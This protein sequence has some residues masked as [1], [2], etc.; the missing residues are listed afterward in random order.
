MM[1]QTKER[2]NVTELFSSIITRLFNQPKDIYDALDTYFD[3]DEVE[4]GRMRFASV[5]NTPP[6]IAVQ[7]DRVAFDNDT[8]T[9]RKLS[10]HVEVKETIFLDRYLEDEDDSKLM[11]RR[12]QTWAFKRELREKEDR[13]RELAQNK[14]RPDVHMVFED[15]KNILQGLQSIIGEENGID[16]DIDVQQD[17]VDVLDQ[18][19][20]SIRTEYQGSSTRLHPP[21]LH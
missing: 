14:T 7:L 21:F 2:K 1:F 17:T 3:L 9:Y 4:N 5:A 12:K 13:R 11:E 8:K 19:A 16:D 6:V 20:Q 10:H 18:L 15:A